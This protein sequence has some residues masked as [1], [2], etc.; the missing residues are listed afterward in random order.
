MMIDFK[1]KKILKDIKSKDPQERYN[2]LVR[3]EDLRKSPISVP[4]NS[5]KD[6]IKCSTYPFDEPFDNW[7]YPSYHLMTFIN[8]FRHEDLIKE[9]IKAYE[10]LPKESKAIAIDFLCS[11][12]DGQFLEEILKLYE[13]AIKEKSAIFPLNSLYKK[14]KLVIKM[15]EKF[16]LELENT[17]YKPIFYRLLFFLL[18]NKYISDFQFEHTASVLVNDYKNLL[19]Q[20]KKYDE[21]YEP[22]YVYNA[23]KSSYLNLRSELVLYIA[24]MEFYYDEKIES[25]LKEALNFKDPTVKAISVIICLQKNIEITDELLKECSMNIE[26]SENFYSELLKIEKEHLFTIKENKQSFFAKSHLFNYLVNH[27]DYMRYPDSI[28]IEKIMDTENYFG[29]AV[30]YY[31]MSFQAKDDEKYVAFVGGYSLEKEDDVYIWEGTKTDFVLFD[32]KKIEEYAQK[33]LME[34][35]E[36]NE[37]EKEEIIYTSKPK[38][39]KWSYLLYFLTVTKGV[40]M[41]RYNEL[42]YWLIYGVIAGSAIFYTLKKLYER[43]R[44]EVSLNHVSIIFKDKEIVKKIEFTEIKKIV[45]K[46]NKVVIYNKQGEMILIIPKNYV[47]YEYFSQYIVELTEHLKEKPYIQTN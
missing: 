8:T 19:A 18:Q 15:L 31:M 9:V 13:R 34:D 32:E 30:R 4:I 28:H 44:F 14:P 16:Y 20:Y 3:L 24:L 43:E 29:E 2:A 35:R 27:P 39:N 42:E 26:C 33:F 46:K 17:P 41:Y 11:M 25:L 23:W 21:V 12:D 7:D 45:L 1:I 22:K 47:D 36:E 5:L 10:K 40:T 37:V 38:W 6:M